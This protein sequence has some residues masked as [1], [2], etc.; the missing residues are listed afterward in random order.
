ML[1]LLATLVS[2]KAVP[3]AHA[4]DIYLTGPGALLTVIYMA[5]LLFRPGKL[6]ASLCETCAAP[7][8]RPARRRHPH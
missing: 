4:S 8:G 2:G 1:F 5:G 3:N 7:H 6:P